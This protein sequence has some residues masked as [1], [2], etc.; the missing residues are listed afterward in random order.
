MQWLA[1]SATGRDVNVGVSQPPS[2]AAPTVAHIWQVLM[3]D[4]IKLM[5]RMEPLETENSN[6]NGERSKL[7]KQETRERNQLREEKKGAFC[8]G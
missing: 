3:V 7:K 2:P 8:A 1:Q 4:N 6:L 5:S